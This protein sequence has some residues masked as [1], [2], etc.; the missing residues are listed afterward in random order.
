ML[1][2]M[3]V[4]DNTVYRQLLANTIRAQIPSLAVVE[5]SST[6]EALHKV[7]S[8]APD[9]IFMDIRLHGD[10]G[11]EL[12]KIIKS[13]YPKII[14]AILTSHDLPEYREAARKYKADHFLWKG[15]T[16][17]EEILKLINSI[18]SERR[19]GLGRKKPK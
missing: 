17:T 12:T 10:S 13:R 3:I 4:E 5:A 11:L 8:T 1:T 19:I 7:K 9:L 14:I 16:T 2:V 6:T 18:L 15:S